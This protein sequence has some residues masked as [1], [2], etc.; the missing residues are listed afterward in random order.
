MKLGVVESL[1]VC[2]TEL[3]SVAILGIHA[4]KNSNLL[5]LSVLGWEYLCVY[6]GGRFIVV[7]RA[8]V[9]QA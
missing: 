9:E 6:V 3:N 8:L 4:K 7:G 2:M 1:F 5:P